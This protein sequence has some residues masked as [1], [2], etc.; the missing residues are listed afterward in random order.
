M[1]HSNEQVMTDR[2]SPDWRRGTSYEKR[3]DK[4]WWADEL[5]TI[6]S[7]AIDDGEQSN[8]DDGRTSQ[9]Q[10]MHEQTMTDERIKLWLTKAS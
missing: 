7:P 2:Q 6:Y 3:T 8:D 5:S 10:Q 4:R 1:I 9:W